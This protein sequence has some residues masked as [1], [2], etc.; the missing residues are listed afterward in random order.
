MTPAISRLLKSLILLPATISLVAGNARAEDLLS[1]WPDGADPTVVGK[2]MAENFLPRQFRYETN[3]AKSHLGVI[4]PE[5]ITWYGALTFAELSGNK[6]LTGKLTEKFAPLLG[7]EGASR[8]NRSPHVDYR[9]FGIVPLELYLI[10]KDER[11]LK[12]GTSFADAQWK[13][14]TEDGIT[15]EARYWIDDMYMVPALQVQAFRA[16]RDPVYLDH[17]ALAMAAY[18]DKLQ[19]PNGLFHHGPDSQFFWGRG[20]GWVAAGMAEL[21]RELPQDHPLRPRIL[22]GFQTM[23]KSLLACQTPEGMWRQLLD[24]PESW[25]ESSGSA[26]FAFAMVSGV[27]SDWLDAETYAPAARKSWIALAALVDADGNISDVCIGTDK[28]FSKEFYLE[29]PRANGDLHGQA[30]MLWT[31]SALL[32]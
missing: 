13:T 15:T 4:Y 8:I 23:M 32:R 10:N 21:L 12:L 24:D 25:V 16:T 5:A 28:G 18:L 7:E 19:Q 27:K 20:N 1:D 6:E 22:T 9:L 14:T 11:C 3:P 30:P 17:A 29:R 2:R 26:M 31:A